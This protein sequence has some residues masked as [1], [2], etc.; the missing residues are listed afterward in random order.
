MGKNNLISTLPMFK[1]LLLAVL[2]SCTFALETRRLQKPEAKAPAGKAYTP[3]KVPALNDG[4]KAS[5]EG[6]YKFEM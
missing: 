6:W 5:R 1:I 3:I 2:L 4:W